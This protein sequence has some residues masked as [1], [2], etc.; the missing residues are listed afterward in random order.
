M[1]ID[2]EGK[3]RL[4]KKTNKI[5]SIYHTIK[6]P[7]IISKAEARIK[8][9]LNA[10]K[11]KRLIKNRFKINISPYSQC[12]NQKDFIMFIEFENLFKI[13]IIFLEDYPF[14]PP[15]VTYVS[16]QYLEH[17]FDKENKLKIS[18]LKKEKWSPVLELNSIINSIELKIEEINPIS[19]IK[20]RKRN[21]FEYQKMHNIDNSYILPIHQIKK[22]KIF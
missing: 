22:L 8:N 11:N 16:G 2:F 12:E 20:V 10:I 13:Q 4:M 6:K 3:N 7:Y 21:Y 18:C 1:D 14:V 9:D 15:N 5:Y 19:P 17:L